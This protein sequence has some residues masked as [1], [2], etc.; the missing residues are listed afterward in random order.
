[1]LK[2]QTALDSIRELAIIVASG[3]VFFHMLLWESESRYGQALLPLLLV[4]NTLPIQETKIQKV[5][6]IQ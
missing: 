3:Y 1:M 5:Q 6:E 4:I 2:R